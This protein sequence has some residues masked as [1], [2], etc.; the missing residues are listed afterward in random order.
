[1]GFPMREWGWTES[2]VWKYLKE[3]EITIPTRTDCLVC[4]FQRL[5]E[6]WEFWK[7]GFQDGSQDHKDAWLEG[8]RQ[9]R[10]IGHTFRSDTRDT[11]P[12]SMEGLRLEFGK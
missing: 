3:R 2:D 7:A 12:A 8:E 10:E 11:W 1:M 9:E 5:I 6:W 4:F